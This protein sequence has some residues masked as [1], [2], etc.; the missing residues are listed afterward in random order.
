MYFCDNQGAIRIARNLTTSGRTKHLDLKLQYVKQEIREDERF[1]ISYVNSV[2]N[3]AD[4]FAKAL[5]KQP[6]YGLREAL[7]YRRLSEAENEGRC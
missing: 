5:S 1:Q 3:V 6:F 7:F 2:K 4:V